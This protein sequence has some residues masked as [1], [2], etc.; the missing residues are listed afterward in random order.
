[1]FINGTSYTTESDPFVSSVQFTT[2]FKFDS[3]I[4]GDNFQELIYWRKDKTAERT[5]IEQNIINYYGL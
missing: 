5:A 2:L 3:Y 1:M 4:S